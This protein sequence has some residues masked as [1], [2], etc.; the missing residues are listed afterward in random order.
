MSETARMTG[1]PLDGQ[2]VELRPAQ[3]HNGEYGG[4]SGRDTSPGAPAYVRDKLGQW[5]WQG[6][7]WPID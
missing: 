1:G 5:V 7:P 6:K 2:T 4:L 3:E